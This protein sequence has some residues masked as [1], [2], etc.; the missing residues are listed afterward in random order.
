MYFYCFEVRTRYRKRVEEIQSVG[1]CK[2]CGS[3]VGVLYKGCHPSPA[4]HFNSSLS[5]S[6]SPSFGISPSLALLALLATLPSPGYWA[7]NESVG[8]GRDRREH[9]RLME[10][11]YWGIWME[12][13]WLGLDGPLRG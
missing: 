12:G 11:A 1:T 5:N 9:L 13:R 3:L 7:L 4:G 2:R 10:P 8:A 6:P